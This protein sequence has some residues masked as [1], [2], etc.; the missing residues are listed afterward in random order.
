[1]MTLIQQERPLSA[2]VA[3]VQTHE[4]SCVLTIGFSDLTIHFNSPADL[5]DWCRRAIEQ[6]ERLSAA[7]PVEFR[8]GS[9]VD[10][11]EILD[12]RD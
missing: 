5:I 9:G 11:A 7:A 4:P 10:L 12:P 1:M 3:W 2:R 8:D 6:A